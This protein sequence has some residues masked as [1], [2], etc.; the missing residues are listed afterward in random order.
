MFFIIIKTPEERAALLPYLKKKGVFAVFHYLPLHSSDFFQAKHDG[1]KLPN[2]DHFS[3]C[4]I[5]LPFYN[6]M[7]K[8]EIDY[9]VGTIKKFYNK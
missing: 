4:I 6:E 5:R 3:D 1:R 9:V 2:T 7:K 8:D